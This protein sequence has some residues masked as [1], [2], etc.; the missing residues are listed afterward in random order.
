M[1]L[2]TRGKNLIKSHEGLVLAVYP[3]PATGGAP[4]T[5]G[6]GHTGSDVKPGMKVTQAMADAWFDKDVAKFESGVSS[7]ITAQQLRASLMQ[8]VAGLQHWPW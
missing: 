2:S 8:C 6:Y 5:A 1:K 7:L 3:D 4:Y